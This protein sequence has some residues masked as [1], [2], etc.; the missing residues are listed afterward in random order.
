MTPTSESAWG[1]EFGIFFSMVSLRAAVPFISTDEFIALEVRLDP[2]PT[3][4][5]RLL[6]TVFPHIGTG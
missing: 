4:A 1:S 6:Q 3:E 2:C 5:Y